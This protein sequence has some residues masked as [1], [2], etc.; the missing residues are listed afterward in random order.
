MWETWV[1]TGLGLR[2]YTGHVAELLI[3]R[4]FPEGGLPSEQSPAQQPFL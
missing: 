3:L 2:R 4:V 1:V